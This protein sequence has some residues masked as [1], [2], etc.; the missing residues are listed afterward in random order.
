MSQTISIG[1]VG[2]RYWSY[3]AGAMADCLEQIVNDD[4][5]VKESIPRTVL[6][7]ALRFFD[8]VLQELEPREPSSAVLRNREATLHA[9]LIARSAEQDAQ[10]PSHTPTEREGFARRFREYRDLLRWLSNGNENRL[11]DKQRET[12]DAL[13]KFFRQ[14]EARGQE[15][16]YE[17]RVAFGGL[18]RTPVH[19]F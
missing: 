1:V 4:G 15:D 3:M 2:P 17:E 9:Y 19:V 6:A 5:Q 8:L 10:G 11:D 13:V 7:D 16:S 14:I 18:P 12:A